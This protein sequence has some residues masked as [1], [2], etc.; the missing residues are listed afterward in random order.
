[1]F[2]INFRKLKLRI[3]V[4]S[5]ESPGYDVEFPEAVRKCAA[6][7]AEV[8]RVIHR[9]LDGH[10]LTLRA[11]LYRSIWLL[12]NPQGLYD[13]LCYLWMIERVVWQASSRY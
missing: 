3:P 4:T 6:G 9:F 8:R 5:S 1:M 2:A 10:T 13:K 7:G 12:T 11:F